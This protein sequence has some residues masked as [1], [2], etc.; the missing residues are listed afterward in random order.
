MW[1]TGEW[2]IGGM[3][4]RGIWWEHK[5]REKGDEDGMRYMIGRG[6]GIGRE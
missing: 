4:G 3:E 2:A 5:I 1:K 6:M